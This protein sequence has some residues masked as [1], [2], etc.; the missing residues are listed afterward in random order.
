M[1][2]RIC[3]ECGQAFD[4]DK[5]WTCVARVANLEEITKLSFAV[6]GI[7]FMGSMLA[8]FTYNPLIGVQAEAWVAGWVSL[9]VVIPL[10]TSAALFVAGQV[11]RFA[12]PLK[13]MLI[14]SPAFLVLTAAFFF[15]NGALDSNAPVEAH[16]LVASEPVPGGWQPEVLVVSVPW[17]NRQLKEEVTVNDPNSLVT[18]GDPIRLDVH[19]GKFSVPLYDNIQISNG[20]GT[21]ILSSR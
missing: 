5:C 19:A 2:V 12:I 17:N 4:G 10:V 9:L 6:A 21:P 18:P 1:G 14:L 20:S 13:R 11:E 15:L 16:S 3:S 7:G 8:M